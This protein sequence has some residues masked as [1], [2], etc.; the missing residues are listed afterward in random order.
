MGVWKKT[1]CV[2]LHYSKLFIVDLIELSMSASTQCD[3]I[4]ILAVEEK[5]QSE[6]STQ[7]SV[8]GW[9]TCTTDSNR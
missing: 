6:K 8:F 1:S 4:I 7:N 3:N 9:L 5:A 2:C